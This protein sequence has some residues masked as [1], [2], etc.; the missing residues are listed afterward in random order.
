M[1]P[2][3]LES[4]QCERDRQDKQWGGAEHDDHH[5]KDDWF[6]FIQWQIDS[7][8][9]QP[10]MQ[11]VEQARYTLVKIAALAVAGIESIDRKEG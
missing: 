8:K 7:F 9:A 3:I 11:R 5:S 2:R 4:I 6:E 10:G 1:T